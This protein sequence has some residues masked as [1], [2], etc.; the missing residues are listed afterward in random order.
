VVIKNIFW[1]VASCSLLKVNRRFGLPSAVTLVFYSAYSTLKIEEIY[2]CEMSVD[3]QR[4][5]L[6]FILK[7]ITL[8]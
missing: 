2:R 1:D 7:D 8:Q 6:R 5:T 4:T 3:F